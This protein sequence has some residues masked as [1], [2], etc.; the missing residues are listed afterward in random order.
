M[1]AA[2]RVLN[3]FK[4]LES[5]LLC[6]ERTKKAASLHENHLP[7]LFW[8]PKAQQNLQTMWQT[9]FAMHSQDSQAEKN[10]EFS[11]CQPHK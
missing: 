7:H 1:D 11:F 5:T 2:G 6:G 10:T 9:D 3:P 8:T 4:L